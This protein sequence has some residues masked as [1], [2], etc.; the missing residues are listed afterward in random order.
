MKGKKKGR[1]CR[2]FYVQGRGD[3]RWG[4]GERREAFSYQVRE[5]GEKESEPIFFPKRR[6][7]EK[8]KGGKLRHIY[9]LIPL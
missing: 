8:K 1:G 4:R 2:L 5:R 6:C 7:R 3:C 9:Y